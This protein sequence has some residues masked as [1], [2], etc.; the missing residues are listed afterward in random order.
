MPKIKNKDK[1]GRVKEQSITRNELTPLLFPLPKPFQGFQ[2]RIFHPIDF[3]VV[4]APPP[5]F[6]SLKISQTKKIRQ[7]K[8]MDKDKK[9]TKQVRK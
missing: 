7:D 8:K 2:S 3:L 6:R 4:E 5:P 9:K 1:R